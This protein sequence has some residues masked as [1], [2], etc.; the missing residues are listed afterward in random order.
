MRG[1]PVR[2][3]LSVLSLSS[4]EYWITRRSLSSGGALRRPVGG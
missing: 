3:G 2:R 1:Y 4:L